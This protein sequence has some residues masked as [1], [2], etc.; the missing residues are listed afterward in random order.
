M[1]KKHRPSRAELDQIAWQTIHQASVVRNRQPAGY[2]ASGRPANFVELAQMMADRDEE[3]AWSDTST[4]STASGPQ[5][6]SLSA[7]WTP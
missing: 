3:M 4:S 1:P 2:A 7:L 5:A 6:S